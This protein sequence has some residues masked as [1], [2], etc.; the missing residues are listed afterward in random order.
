MQITVFG[1]SGKVG[2]LI[3]AQG[4]RRGY[5]IVAFVHAQSPF[6]PSAQ[7]IIRKGDVYN[8]R[9]VAEA[10]RGSQAVVSC[11]GSWHTRGKD[12][13]SRFVVSIVP[14]MREQNIA[15]IVT[16]TGVGVQQKPSWL[17]R[18][19]MRSLPLVPVAGKVFA[20]ADR[21]VQ[22][23]VRSGLQWTTICSPVMNAGNKAG[24]VLRHHQGLP[25]PRV[26]RTAVAAAMLDQLTATDH[27][28]EAVSVHHR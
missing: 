16:L 1:A 10:I 23:L 24:Y 22:L 7:L 15:R 21:H 13:L 25:L 18:A 11:L 6:E 2:R 12:V 28:A 19:A 5:T 20:D 9:D 3:V 26:T 14:A 4:L 8:A 17:Y 27:I